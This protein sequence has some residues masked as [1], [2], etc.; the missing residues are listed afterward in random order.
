MNTVTIGNKEITFPSSISEI[1][2]ED[3]KKIAVFVFQDTVQNRISLMIHL[4]SNQKVM[5]GA[6]EKLKAESNDSNRLF[7]LSRIMDFIW[8]KQEVAPDTVV[9][10]MISKFKLKGI[11]YWLPQPSLDDVTMNEWAFLHAYLEEYQQDY[12]EEK[13]LN[14]VACCCRE[15]RKK[16]EIDAEDFDGFYRIH[17]N[18]ETIS[19]RSQ[20][21]GH[22]PFYVGRAVLD[23]L[24]RCQTMLKA[25]YAKL[26]EAPA[27]KGPNWGYQGM[28]FSLGDTTYFQGTKVG[29]QLL[30]ECMSYA[31]KKI[32]DIELAQE[33][34][35]ANSLL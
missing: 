20:K 4:A 32:I 7:Q 15:R 2:E 21:M 18:P 1:T 6:L 33:S 29:D 10:P 31:M 34:E 8:E 13:L 9:K 28:I 35:T 27:S 5:L 22:V 19:R 16:K 14:I 3:W 17:F 26:F 23:Y 25:R 30:H 24:S 12:E 11:T